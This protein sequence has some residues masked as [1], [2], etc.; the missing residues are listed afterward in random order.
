MTGWTDA[1][2]LQAGACRALGSGL[3]ARVCDAL[4]RVIAADHG[5]VAQRVKS[6]P[7]D[8]TYLG[9]SVPLRLCGALHGLVLTDQAP[10]L[11][12]C[13][14]FA[15]AGQLDTEIKACLHDHAAWFDAWLDL[16]PQTNE[17]ARSAV[18]I[19]GSWFLSGVAQPVPFDLYELGAS[20]GLNLNFP[21]YH[22]VTDD[23]VAPV[24]DEMMTVFL[25]PV[26]RSGMPARAAFRAASARGVD[27]NPLDPQSDA[28]RLLS[29]IWP[30]QHARMQ[31]MRAALAIAQDHPPQVDQ[32]DAAAWLE[33]QLSAPAAHGRL[34]YHTVAA[35]YF[36][37]ETRARVEAALLHAGAQATAERPLAHLSMESDG[38]EMALTLRLWD[39]TARAWTLGRAH[40]HAGWIDWQPTETT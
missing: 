27:L 33:A 2:A 22:L 9:D 14:G 23:D 5:P 3:T 28:L 25:R 37:P 16:A 31:R 15:V 21:L 38:P 8:A 7:G 40:P 35:Q 4:T 6:W 12:A 39:G 11:G 29:Y 18:L 30:D 1:M 20:A 17:V 34:V 10:S 19:A 13:Y 36:P 24:S 26:W 32:G